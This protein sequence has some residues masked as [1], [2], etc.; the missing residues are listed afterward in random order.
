[1]TQALLAG[2]PI[3]LIPEQLEQLHTALRVEKA[4][5]GIV[6]RRDTG[7]DRITESLSGLA[8]QPR[9]L[10]A[11][12]ALSEKYGTFGQT[13]PAAAVVAHCEGLLNS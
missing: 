6:V 12:R 5:A 9:F 1:V 4:G 3:L 8:G 11:S 7:Q 2:K 10:R 13:D